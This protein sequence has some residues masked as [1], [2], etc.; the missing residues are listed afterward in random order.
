MPRP[1]SFQ[2][3]RQAFI[4]ILLEDHNELTGCDRGRSNPYAILIRME[5]G[6]GV[7]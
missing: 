1:D 7:I 2:K 3:T 4:L 6:S 5:T